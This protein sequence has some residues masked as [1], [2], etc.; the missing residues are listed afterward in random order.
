MP[1]TRHQ[2]ASLR[3]QGQTAAICFFAAIVAFSGIFGDAGSAVAQNAPAG[4]LAPGNAAVT[5]FSGA[6][7]PA[8]IPPGVD[9]RETTFI[10]L[11]GPS[12]RI[13]DLQNMAGPPNGQLVPAPKPFTVTAAQVGQVF[14]VVLDNSTP[15]N[16][17]VA[18]TSAYGLPIVAPGADGQPRH[19]RTGVPKASFM[20]GLWG[21]AAP[22]GGPGS[23]WKID[24][25]T[26]SVNLFANVTL[27]GALNS[28]P[29][30]GGL[31]FD[32]DSNSL[33]AADRDTGM[34][35]RFA[36]TGAERGRYDHGVQ[37]RAAQG[38]PPV[39]FD[40]KKRLAITNPKFDSEQ[41]ATWSYAPPE[42]LIFGLGVSRGRLYYA[43]AAD[44]QIWS[45]GISPD[46]RSPDDATREIGVP[47]AEGPTEIL[48]NHF[49]DRGR[50]FLAERPAPTGAYD[51][52]ALTPEGIG[53]ILRYAITDSYQGAP[54]IWQ[55]VP[56][57]YAI[58]FRR[59]TATAMAALPSA[60]I[61][62][63]P[64]CSTVPRA[65][66]CCGRAASG[67]ASRPIPGS[68]P[69]AAI[70]AGKC[71]RPARQSHR[72]CAA[73]ECAA[74]QNLVHRLRRSRR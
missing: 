38:L 45:V 14:A 19:V 50:M 44:L 63:Q 35:H 49:D 6:I 20:P 2:P 8:Q 4:L 34:I 7:P 41:P 26:G 42:R 27:G 61:T 57:E 29:A 15:P 69:D 13:V 37:G 64:A 3:K 47:P 28:G 66:V 31:A 24:G 59:N 40:P 72:A 30:L 5:G 10:D 58:G 68:P 65:A 18:A 67:C 52:K 36:M 73:A 71:R 9:P 53:R 25:V 1:S 62:T 33:F 48:E 11:D 70:R 46:G 74:A 16:I 43:V 32:P 21:G 23:I 39:P 22:N 51:F 17:Y 56:D 54:R 12:V 55:Q 60:S